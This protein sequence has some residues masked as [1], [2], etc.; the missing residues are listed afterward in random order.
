MHPRLLPTLLVVC[1][2]AASAATRAEDTKPA[3]ASPAPAH[4]EAQTQ[5][6]VQMED[7][8]S[9]FRKLRRQIGD[10][11]QNT[12]SLELTGKLITLA[13]KAAK[14]APAKADD[15]PAADR[16]KFIAGYQAGMDKLVK[17]FR[18]L[19]AALKEGNNAEAEQ[20]LQKIASFQKEAHREF[21]RPKG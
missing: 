10:A 2:A 18:T 17:Q 21:R 4:K 20:L 11:S 14:L 12:S 3:A 9:V 16:A 1:L 5:L 13:E 6:E 19:E 7:L 8:N 15:V